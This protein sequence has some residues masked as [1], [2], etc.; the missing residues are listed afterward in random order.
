M[1]HMQFFPG[2]ATSGSGGF[3]SILNGAWLD[4]SAD[5]L[6]LT[7]S[8]TAPWTF[9]AWVKKCENGSEL[10][11]IGGS[12]GEVHFNS[13]DTLEAEGTSS[14]AL[15][16]DLNGWMHI[17]VSDNGLY[18][19][20]V[21]HGS[22]TTTNL[23]NANLF[24]GFHG[25]V[26]EVHLKSGTDAYT[27]FGEVDA[28][29]GGWVPIE[30]TSGEHYLKFANASDLGENSGSGSDWTATSM[31]TDN[32]VTDSPIDDSGNN[33]GNYPTFNPLNMAERSSSTVATTFN[34]SDANL[35]CSPDGTTPSNNQSV[36]L[37]HLL[38]PS[39]KWHLEFDITLTGSDTDT[40]CAIHLVPL[41][42]WQSRGDIRYGSGVF[43]LEV[44]KA[45]ATV[46]SR[47]GGLG[48]STGLAK[49]DARWALD[50]DLS[51]IS[52]VTIVSSRNGSPE[53]TDSSMSF[54]DEPYIISVLRHTNSNRDFTCTINAGQ[55]GFDD[56]PA[57]NHKALVTANLP[58][59][60]VPDPSAYVFMTKY[61]GDGTAIGSGGQAVTG[62][63]D[64][65]GSNV[66]PDWVW[67]K[68]L[69][70]TDDHHLYDVIRG[71]TKHFP[72][73]STSAQS[74]TAEGLASFDAGGF[75]VGSDHGVNASGEDYAALCMKLGGAG[76][77]NS[78][79]DINSTV[80]VAAHGKAAL[81]K[82][83]GNNTATQTVG[84]GMDTAPACILLKKY[85]GSASNF[86]MYHDSWASDPETDY[87]MLSQT[88]ALTDNAA[89]WGDTAPTSS[90]F[91]VSN[92]AD[93]NG[94]TDN[95]IALCLARCPGLIGIGSYTGNGN[96][97]GPMVIVDDGASGFQP[98]YVLI[99]EIPNTADWLWF[100]SGRGTYNGQMYRMKTNTT[101]AENT[102]HV[103]DFLANGFKLRVSDSD[104]NQS[105]T[106]YL[107]LA[108]AEFPFGGAG[109]AQA[110][111]R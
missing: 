109:I 86:T 9:S 95:V 22:V 10:P 84:H 55:S 31:G 23:S 72:S 49:G 51:T 20:G 42:L 88:N 59:P 14:T 8:L 3:I 108:F 1:L 105:G 15:F 37:T 91:T 29:N 27:T 110:R 47:T 32:Q 89:Y 77:A 71:A 39:G 83:T 7:Y 54:N 68:N 45:G 74:T 79:G 57:T 107:Y 21:S 56:T 101:E 5:S 106:A 103:M 104:K 99:R 41:S 78:D 24:D 97:D 12:G 76:S 53:A 26:A 48:G 28:I 17:H 2:A 61:T 58:A 111:A 44:F 4:G 80:S 43:Y 102:S 35:T 67:I 92:N 34:F 38:P 100:D 50:I 63:Q 36:A 82:Y 11:I 66:T 13:N 69:D 98:A 85:D 16:R 19:N 64:G 52:S 30:A 96:A 62:F 65:P 40:S 75:T 70:Q 93:I 46:G 6:D 33:T 60:T 18:V 81:V 25:V 94:H 90:V 87:M 73:N